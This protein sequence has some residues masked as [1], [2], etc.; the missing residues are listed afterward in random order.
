MG[1]GA[2]DRDAAPIDLFS[3]AASVG[4]MADLG[5]LRHT[6]MELPQV[7]HHAGS[8]YILP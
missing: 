5:L 2:A 1:K 8:C 6:D 7:S 4:A 3:R